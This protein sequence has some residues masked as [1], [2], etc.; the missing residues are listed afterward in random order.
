MKMKEHVKNKRRRRDK[1]CMYFTLYQSMGKY[2][3]SYYSQKKKRF[4]ISCKMSP[5][6]TICMKCQ[7]I[8]R[9]KIR[10]LFQ[11]VVC[12]FFP[13]VLSVKGNFVMFV[14]GKNNW[15]RLKVNAY[16]K[17][18]WLSLVK[19]CTDDTSLWAYWADD[20]LGVFIIPW[21]KTLT[22][23]VNCLFRQI[24]NVFLITP[25]KYAMTFYAK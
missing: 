5:Y 21:K 7:F 12:W 15:Q 11:N 23:Y 19:H 25:R 17:N 24:A 9:G 10:K 20:S 16:V 4:D 3:F 2:N 18:E 1:S 8:F 6:E 22:F 14:L 13:S